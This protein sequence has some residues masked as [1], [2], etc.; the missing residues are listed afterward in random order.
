MEKLASIRGRRFLEC[1]RKSA[2]NQTVEGA[3]FMGQKWG[4]MGQNGAK[5]GQKNQ[6]TLIYFEM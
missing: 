1:K 2:F 4:K 6:F 3:D 5:M